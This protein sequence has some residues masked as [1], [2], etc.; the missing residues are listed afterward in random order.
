MLTA[1]GPVVV[2]R[3]LPLGMS[4]QHS[5]AGFQ[6]IRYWGDARSEAFEQ[7]MLLAVKQYIATKQSDRQTQLPPT[8]MLAISGG[9]DNGAFGAGFLCGWT[10][11]GDRPSFSIVTGV[12]TGS[13]IAPFAFLGPD[14][15]TRLR[16]AFT[17]VTPDRI[18][19]VRD[20]LDILRY[21]SVADPKP[22]HD[23]TR[24]YIDDDMLRAIAREHSRGRR[25]YVSTTDMDAQRPVIWNM[26]RIAS[27]GTP[28]AL[29]LFRGILVASSSIPGAFPP[30]YIDVQANGRTYDTMHMD[31][32]VTRHIFLLNSLMDLPR[33]RSRIEAETDLIPAIAKP[34]VYVIRN[35]KAAPEPQHVRPSLGSIAGRAVSTMIK[36]QAMGDIFRLYAFAQ[37]DGYEFLLAHMPDDYRRIP[38][39]EEFDQKAMRHMFD[40]G[41]KLGSGGYPW[42]HAPPGL[43]L[44]A[45]V[46]AADPDPT[47]SAP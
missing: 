35:D 34:R 4:E 19:I 18:M 45:P 33:L 47:A 12:S 8:R 7:D 27:Y 6:D 46:P 5:V 44:H 26:G 41:Y 31:G 38:D 39:T 10:A 13:L 30:V 25:L 3:P 11:H 2:R 29:A 36:S 14:Y 9:G 15:D 24:T 21:A 28:E 42:L 32:G 20:L 23:L 40:I 17:T 22:L 43:E 16:D 1:C 37:R